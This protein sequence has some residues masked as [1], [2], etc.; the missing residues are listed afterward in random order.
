M[1]WRIFFGSSMVSVWFAIRSSVHALNRMHAGSVEF[2]A[3]DSSGSPRIEAKNYSVYRKPCIWRKNLPFRQ[4]LM[5]WLVLFHI[6]GISSSQLTNSYFLR[7]VAQPPNHQSDVV[8]QLE[9]RH[10]YDALFSFVVSQINATVSA[11]WQL[12]RFPKGSGIVPITGIEAKFITTNGTK[13]VW[14]VLWNMFCFPIQ[15][16]NNNHPNWLYNMFQRG[17]YTTNQ[18]CPVEIARFLL[19]VVDL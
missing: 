5:F 16:W 12:P 6:L 19:T 18:L 11:S 15:F 4:G 10:L 14:L 17:S 8:K 2:L 9:A 3:S 7:K 1:R 13:I